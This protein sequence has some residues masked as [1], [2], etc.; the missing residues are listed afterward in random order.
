[1]PLRNAPRLKDGANFL[2]YLGKPS[3]SRLLIA[4]DY[5]AYKLSQRAGLPNETELGYRRDYAPSLDDAS[6]FEEFIVETNRRR[7]GRDG[8]LYPAQRYSRSVLRYAVTADDRADSL[9]EWYSDQKSK[10]IVV[11]IPWG[12][13]MV[14]DPSSKRA[15]FGFS[16]GI[17]VR[18]IATPGIDVS[19]FELNDPSGRMSAAEVTASYPAARNGQIA[20]P[21]RITWKTWEKVTPN[22]YLKKAYVALQKQ[23]LELTREESRSPGP[24]VRTA[25]AGRSP[26]QSAK[27]TR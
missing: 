25:D 18:T 16:P 19:V 6:G 26:D 3:D 22:P 12:K 23:N 1:L 9:P 8:T 5:S 10:T 15:F 13:L 2:L 17:Q 7:F 20:D 27:N 4:Q 11:R 24:G 21:A 14:T